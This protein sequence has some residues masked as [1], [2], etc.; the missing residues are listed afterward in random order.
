MQAP[1]ARSKVFPGVA[2]ALLLSAGAAGCSSKTSCPQGQTDCG[3]ACVDLSTD[4]L[5]CGACNVSCDLGA[6]CSAGTCLCPPEKPD[7]CGIQCV[8]RQTDEANC[9][10]CGHACGLGTCGAGTCTC[11]AEPATVTLCP[12]DPATGTCVDTATNAAHCGGCGQACFAGQVC[13]ASTCACP[14]GTVLC[15]AGAAQACVDTRTDSRN[16]GG[17]G[18]ACAAGQVCTAGVCEASCAA[19]LTLCGG[20]CVDLRSDPAHCGSCLNACASGQSCTAGACQASCTTVTCGG[21]CCPGGS[22]CCPDGCPHQHRNFVGTAAE[23]TWYDCT[24]SFTYDLPAA[25]SAAMK[26]SPDGNAVNTAQSCPVLGGGSICLVWQK[27]LVGLDIGCG[28]WCYAG[29]YA[30]TL[31]VTGTYSCPCP[32]ALGTDWY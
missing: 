11:D 6:S 9:G 19:G 7:T 18:N 23:Q 17:C 21:T 24:P 20:A 2:L 26:W 13:S 8:N 5:H 30:G 4:T 12:A 16:C 14:A 1:F 10:T 27:P 25:Q 28:V 31:Q 3:G 29:P 15:P 32:T 22:A